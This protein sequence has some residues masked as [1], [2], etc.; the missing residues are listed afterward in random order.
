MA[1]YDVEG[2]LLNTVYDVEGNALANAYDVDGN[3]LY[4]TVFSDEATITAVYTSTSTL[5]PQGGCM[6][7]D[8]NIYA[9]LYMSGIFSKYNIFT[10]TET[11]VTPPE[12]S[13]SQPWGHA[14]GMAYNPNTGYLYV[15]SMKET[16]E[17]YVFDPSDYSLVDTLYGYQQDGITPVNVWNICYDRLRSRFIV[18]WQGTL[19]FYDDD[20][21][22]I[23]TGSYTTT[24]WLETR[25]DI[26]TDGTY[27]YCV[28][29]NPNKLCILDVNGNFVKVVD[30]S[31]FLGEPESI[32][33]D[34]TTGDFY[35]EGKDTYY[36]IR[37]AEFI[38]T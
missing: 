28:S 8:G 14:N 22:L 25:Q 26:E 5:Q 16:G 3:V 27:I 15:A 24:D 36:V 4:G 12:A 6:D 7:D 2:N 23:S 31:A 38:E 33:Y 17:V 35:I 37:K 9:C 19:W 18:M 21:D 34:W 13:G 20:F 29:W 10:G 30:N 11:R 1:I 32:C